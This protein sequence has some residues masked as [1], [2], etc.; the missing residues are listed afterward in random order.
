[1]KEN[2]LSFLSNTKRLWM[3]TLMVLAGFSAHAQSSWKTME[4]NTLYDE[5]NIFG[6]N[7]LYKFTP[8]SDG[9]LTIWGQDY[10]P[11]VYAEK[12]AEGTDVVYESYISNFS[13][14]SAT[15]QNLNFSKKETAQV[16]AGT[17]YYIVGDVGFSKDKKFIAVMESIT[18]LKLVESSQPLGEMFNITD[19]RDGQAELKFNLPVTSDPWAYLKVGNY[20]TKK[21][22]GKIEVRTGNNTDLLIVNLKDSLTKWKEEGLYKPND[23]V[24]L[25]LTGVKS[26]GENPFI[27]GTDGTLELNWLAPGDLHKATI[28]KYPDPFLSYWLPGDERGIMVIET[29]APL[30]KMEDGQTAVVSMN[31]GSGDLSDAWE[32]QLS[33]DKIK[34]DGNK[35]Y[36][37]FTGDRRTLEDLGLKM[38]WSSIN[39]KV[40]FIKLADGTM[41]FNPS[42]GNY[43]SVAITCNYEEYK[44][45]VVAE[46]TPA[47]DAVLTG[48]SFEVYFSDCS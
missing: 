39:I 34:I 9:T 1:M 29:D 33:S 3:L 30:M 22:D 24:T 36:V 31:M 19:D 7:D 17:T 15:I 28:T 42:A 16:K 37:D 11:K 18:E 48:N 6:V 45:D 23:P 10:C 26:R 41:T 35:L 21:E 12:N 44:S 32:G 13:Y 14:E 43:G 8:E 46:F 2:L 27:Y 5:N 4:L 20:P 25:T 40:N 38:K 47:N